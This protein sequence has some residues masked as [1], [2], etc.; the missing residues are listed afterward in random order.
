MICAAWLSQW[1]LANKIGLMSYVPQHKVA[2]TTSLTRRHQKE[3]SVLS[4]EVMNQADTSD[5]TS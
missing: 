4:E 1:L 3:A 2:I 5:Q